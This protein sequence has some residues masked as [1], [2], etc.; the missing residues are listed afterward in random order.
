MPASSNVGS[1][2]YSECR[3]AVR[4][5]ISNLSIVFRFFFIIDVRRNRQGTTLQ[6]SYEI[7]AH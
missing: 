5:T 3:W 4:E 7:I 6:E 1:E 2:T